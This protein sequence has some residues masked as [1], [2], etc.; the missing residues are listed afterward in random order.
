[1]TCSVLRALA[2]AKLHVVSRRRAHMYGRGAPLNPAEIKC[3]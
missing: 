3:E 1:M 2:G